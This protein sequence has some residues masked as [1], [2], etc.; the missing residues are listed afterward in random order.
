[1]RTNRQTN[2]HDY[3]IIPGVKVIRANNDT[4]QIIKV[5]ANRTKY[6]E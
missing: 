3:Y 4:D 1:M 5:L 2:G 6:I